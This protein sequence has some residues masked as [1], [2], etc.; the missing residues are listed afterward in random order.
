MKPREK[1][2]TAEDIQSSLYYVHVDQP[3]DARLLTPPSESGFPGNGSIPPNRVLPPPVQR[4]AVSASLAPPSM[5]VAPRK[6]V[7]GTL[8]PMNN[9]ANRQNINAG[10]YTQSNSRDGSIYHSQRHSFD[11]KQLQSEND[12][13]PL[14]LRRN[15]DASA[16]AG[17][18]LTLIRRDPASSAQWN[19]ARIEDPPV[20]DVSSSAFNDPA[21]R[22]KTGAPMYI[23]ITNPGYSKFLNNTNRP[24]LMSRDSEVSVYSQESGHNSGHSLPR[25]PFAPPPLS[26]VN[27]AGPTETVF[28]R[29]LWMEGS[30]YSNDGFGHRKINSQDSSI[31]RRSPRSS[32]EG[33]N[34]ERAS[35]D[36]RPSQ[37]SLLP[38]REEQAYNTI[39]VSDKQ[40]SFR[41]YVFTSPWNSRCEFVTGAGGGSLKVSPIYLVPSTKT[42]NVVVSTCHSRTTRDARHCPT[43]QRAPIQPPKQFKRV[44]AHGRRVVQTVLD[45]PSTAKQP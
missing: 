22:K 27:I 35:V 29:R 8:A 4:K 36:L 11:S 15:S 14:P 41:G 26:D 40:S 38:G 6:P 12:R 42:L 32:F 18:S 3:E 16:A 33:H 13:P 20:L 5:S 44:Y 25:V 1:V 23:E 37:P 28:R 21:E 24:G 9:V 10:N 7:S 2:V 39:Q 17:M 43:S 19:V 30:R 31:G 34:R 45:F